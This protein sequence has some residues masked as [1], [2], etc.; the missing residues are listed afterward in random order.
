MGVKHE[1]TFTAIVSNTSNLSVSIPNLR[2]DSVNGITMNNAT[3]FVK[4]VENRDDINIKSKAMA[5]SFFNFFNNFS[6]RMSK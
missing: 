5:L 6:E 3:S 1:P 4:K 2:N